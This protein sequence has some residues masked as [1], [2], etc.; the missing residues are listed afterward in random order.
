M[1]PKLLPLLYLLG[2]GALIAVSTNLAKYSSRVGLDSVTLLIWSTVGVTVVIATLLGVQQ[3]LPKITPRLI[4]YSL[5][6]AVIGGIIPNLIL[7]AA[8]PRVGAGFVVLCLAFPPLFTYIGAMALKMERYSHRRFAGVVLALSGATLLA[9]LRLSSPNANLSWIVATLLLP[10]LLAVG[11]IYRTRRWPANIQ[12]AALV[13]GIL[14]ISSIAYLLL[15]ASGAAALQLPDVF[16][17]GMLIGAQTVIFT[18][19]YL[20]F[21]QL[22]KRGGPVYLS[23]LGSITA[24]VGV[25]IAVL[26]LDETLPKGLLPGAV[27]I[28]S[29]ITLMTR[30]S[31]PKLE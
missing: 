28:I 18:F 21:F 29:G 31:L 3:R 10:I 8:P 27:L 4:E 12:P 1:N 23:L 13:P 7:F 25:P 9:A 19:Q 26:F 11:N 20:F 15:G 5:V 24:I 30:A 14:I 22:Q 17:S 2:T 16:T 6:S